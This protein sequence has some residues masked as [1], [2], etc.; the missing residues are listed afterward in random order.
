M[1]SNDFP[2]LLRVDLVQRRFIRRPFGVVVANCFGA[3]FL[4]RRVLHLTR[5]LII[6]SR[7]REGAVCDHFRR[8]VGSGS[9]T[10]PGVQGLAVSMGKKRRSMAISGR[11]V[12]LYRVFFHDLN[13]TS[14]QAF[15][16]VWGLL[17]VAITRRVEDGG[18]LRLEVL[19]RVLSGGV[20]VQSP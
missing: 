2:Y 9:G 3:T 1:V 19:V 10:A 12:N 6:E 16:L 20:L 4:L 15:R 13:V 14:T 11:A 8:V 7:C 17:R 18:R 5:F